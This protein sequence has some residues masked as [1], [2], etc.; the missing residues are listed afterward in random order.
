[1]PRFVPT[2]FGLWNKE[3]GMPTKRKQQ[4]PVKDESAAHPV[5]SA[6]RP[7]FQEVI[8][9][10]AE[11]DYALSRKIPSVATVNKKTAAQIKAYLVEYGET[12]AKLPEA[13]WKSSVAQWMGT[14]WDVLVDLHTIES[15]ESDL[16]LSA[17]VFEDKKGYRIEIDSVHVP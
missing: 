2:L 8:N 11:E 1:M 5:A 9:A 17:R 10:F 7:I 12:L 15:G 14:H 6:W 13:A 16:V 3:K 4:E